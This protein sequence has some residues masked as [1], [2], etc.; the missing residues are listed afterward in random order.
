MCR[1][2]GHD[3]EHRKEKAC[4]GN[5]DGGI[6]EAKKTSDASSCSGKIDAKEA[7]GGSLNDDAGGAPEV[8][9]F[10]FMRCVLPIS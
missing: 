8:S 9:V 1:S 4:C 10:E 5:D 7:N 2:S 6:A 3:Q